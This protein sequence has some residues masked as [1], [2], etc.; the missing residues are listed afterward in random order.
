MYNS[1]SLIP[2]SRADPLLWMDLPIKLPAMAPG[3]FGGV[4][5]DNVDTVYTSLV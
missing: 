3:A 5:Y 2:R 1:S 4:Y